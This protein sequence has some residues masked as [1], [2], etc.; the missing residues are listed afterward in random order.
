MKD[1]SWLAGAYYWDG[2]VGKHIFI[3]G[4]AVVRCKSR[5]ASLWEAKKFLE[6]IVNGGHVPQQFIDDHQI[7]FFERPFHKYE[8][9]PW[10]PTCITPIPWKVNP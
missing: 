2:R 10:M 7:S 4:T 9:E 3:D 8:D 1:Y 5:T 6:K